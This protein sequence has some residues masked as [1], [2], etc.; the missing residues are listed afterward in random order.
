MEEKKKEKHSRQSVNNK[1]KPDK[2]R[3]TQACERT[4]EDTG[5]LNTI[6][7]VEREHQNYVYL[8]MLEF[9]TL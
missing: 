6:L 4:R 3:H 7:S 1:R 9:Q 8:N 2:Q 5:R